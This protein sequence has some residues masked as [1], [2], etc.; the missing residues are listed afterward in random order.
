MTCPLDGVSLAFPMPKTPKTNV[1]TN[2]GPALRSGH[3]SNADLDVVLDFLKDQIAV[4]KE[5]LRIAGQAKSDEPLK[6]GQAEPSQVFWL[7]S[8]RNLS[9]SCC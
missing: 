2:G 5:F 9:N 6:E 4:K 8:F 3:R 7:K 1:P